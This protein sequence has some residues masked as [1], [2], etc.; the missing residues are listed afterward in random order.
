MI[1]I[2]TSP[3]WV[4]EGTRTGGAA[5]VV[6][7]VALLLVLSGSATSLETVAVLLRLVRPAALT[8]MVTVALSP[9][10]MVPRLHVTVPPASTQGVPWL[11]DAEIKVTAPGRVSVRVAPVAGDWPLLVIVMV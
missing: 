7:A 11:G 3:H 8:T 5:K 9:L 4:M 10:A 2:P 6:T 1:A